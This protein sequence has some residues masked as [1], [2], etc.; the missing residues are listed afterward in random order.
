MFGSSLEA[1]T[2][3]MSGTKPKAKTRRGGGRHKSPAKATT[4]HDHMANAKTA[5]DKGDHQTAKRHALSLV[6]ALHAITKSKTPPTADPMNMNMG[7]M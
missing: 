6:K 7:S 5:M 3:M 1:M 2:G 4:P